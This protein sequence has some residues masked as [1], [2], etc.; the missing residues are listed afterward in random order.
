LN[1]GTIRKFMEALMP[2]IVFQGKS[3]ENADQMPPDIRRL[4]DQ[5][6]GVLADNDRNGVPDILEGMPGTMDVNVQATPVTFSSTQFIVDGKVY[7]NVNDLPPDARQKYEQAMAKAGHVMGD[8]NRNGVPDLLEDAFAAGFAPT[9]APVSPAPQISPSPAISEEA[10]SPNWTLL[11]AGIL[12]GILL[13]ALLA[14]G[15]FVLLPLL[16]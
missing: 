10:A 11:V 5:V 6:M 15:I 13:M 16:K 7:S 1:I 8:T 4:Y 9:S 12:I 2:E 3:Y 14:F